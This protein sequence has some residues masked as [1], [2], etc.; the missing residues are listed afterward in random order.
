MSTYVGRTRK[1]KYPRKI[2]LLLLMSWGLSLVGFSQ[3]LTVRDKVTNTPI[4]GVNLISENPRVHTITTQEGRADITAFKGLDKIEVRAMGYKTQIS[5][6]EE[7]EKNNFEVLLSPLS[8]GLGEVVVSGIRWPQS[9]ET[10]PL[11]IHSIPAKEL[12]LHN[13]QTTADLLGVTGKV[14]IQKSQQ[15]G[16]SPMIR[17]FAAN[18]LLYTVDGIRMNTAIYRGGNIQN[19]ISLDPFAIENTEVLFGPGSVIYGSDAIGGVMSFQTL[20]PRLSLSDDATVS[21]NASVR[22]SSAN[23]EQTG[24]FDNNMGWKKWAMVTSLSSWDFDHLKQGKHG[25]EDYLKPVHVKKIGSVDSVISQTDPLLQIPSAYSQV[26]LMQKI[27]F[28][29]EENWNLEYG[30]YYSK[31]SPYRRYDRHNRMRNGIPRYAEWDYGPQSWM[32]NNVSI[33]HG[34]NRKIY[35][36]LTVRLA[37]QIFEESR[38]DRALNSPE[39]NIQK[40]EV[41]AYS[42]N[43]DLVRSLN[44]STIYYGLEYVQNNVNSTGKLINIS[45]GDEIKGPSRYPR[46]TWQSLATYVNT[47]YPLSDNFTVMAGLRYN[48]ILLNADFDTTFYSLPI[49]TAKLNSGAMTGSVGGIYR[50]SESWEIRANFGT[51]FR[52]PNVDD[53]GKIFDSEPGSV[54]VPNP[55][56]ESE[57]AYNVDMGIAGIL[58]DFIKFDLTGYYTILNHALVRRD[59]QLNGQDSIDYKGTLS[60]VQAIQNAATASVYG[61]QAGLEIKLSKEF[62]FASHINY[63]KGEEELDNGRSSASRHAAPQFGITRLVYKNDAFIFQ[64]YCAYQG[65]RDFKDLAVE[66]QEKDEIYAKDINGNNYSPSWYTLN[67][68]ALYGVTDKILLSAGIE[69]ITDQ[70]YRSYSSGISAPGR[71]FVF[72]LNSKF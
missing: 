6:Y 45:K 23:K 47:K 13:P 28:R 53:M 20:T 38:I 61:V 19:V 1:N 32:M 60:R 2:T 55:H 64:F 54:T 15:G 12:S 42:L 72:S 3:T 67:F 65:Q 8:L 30:F 63:Q 41:S 16:G 43:A 71:N 10:I 69:N 33:S 5:R 11:K 37:Q 48:R 14:F 18:R 49:T 56:L 7:L 50:P 24:H 36:Q 59:F 17:G 39:R 40:E 57:Y 29:P 9:S 66:E 51:A 27:R 68:K 26:N 52:S 44:K 62:S 22:Y 25:P 46:S 31:T 58:G 34:G 21:G 35:D 70:R 4:E